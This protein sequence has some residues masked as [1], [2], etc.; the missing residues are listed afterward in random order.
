[1]PF[2]LGWL[3]P[4]KAD[5]LAHRINIGATSEDPDTPL[6]G[7][8]YLLTVTRG[9]Q[10][11]D[12]D[13][14]QFRMVPVED[15]A[16]KS[17][18]GQPVTV[19]GRRGVESS[20]S[21]GPGGYELYLSHPDG[22]TMYVNVAPHPGSAVPAQQLVDAGRRIAR[23]LRF[24]GNTTV[25]PAFGLRDLPNGMRVCAFEVQKPHGPSADRSRPGTGYSLGTCAVVPPVHVGTATM[26]DS[27]SGTPG[28]P[29]QGHATRYVDEN[30]YVRLWILDAVDGTPVVAAGRV[31]LSD[32]YAVANNLVLPR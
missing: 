22:G 16:F 31:A 12:V 26:G 28:R 24:P 30:G 7:G 1:M 3:P 10:V 20:R 17:G 11:L 21:G 32:L 9:G 15:A 27:P 4:G 14:Q 2:S 23:E 13:V 25:T 29:V 8:E 6:Y 18:P 19:N 5:Y